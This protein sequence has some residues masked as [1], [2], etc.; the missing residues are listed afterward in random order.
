MVERKG[1]DQGKAIQI[2]DDDVL[3]ETSRQTEEDDL[4]MV[5]MKEDVLKENW[6]LEEKSLNASKSAVIPKEEEKD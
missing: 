6:I 2:E 1:P 4:K 3:K 5:M